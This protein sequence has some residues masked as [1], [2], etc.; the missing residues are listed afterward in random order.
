M[1]LTDIL[2]L[3]KQGYKPADIKE[4]IAMA[5]P[6][7]QPEPTPEP[8]PAPT[9]EPVPE[10]TPEPQPEPNAEVIALQKQLDETQKA[11]KAAQSLNRHKQVN[12]Q[13]QS[14]EDNLDD[15]ARSFM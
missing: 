7:A 13:P 9:P 4:L 6:V 12:P 1:N 3:A 14:V 2:A 15:W 10:P 5:E 11:L 8:V